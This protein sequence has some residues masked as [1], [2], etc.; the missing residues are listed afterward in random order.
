MVYIVF[1]RIW[2]V[3]ANKSTIVHTLRQVFYFKLDFYFVKPLCRINKGFDAIEEALNVKNP[4]FLMFFW[5]Y[6]ISVQIDS[7]NNWL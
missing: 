5:R 4:A 1:M 3:Y 2:I 7:I 6:P